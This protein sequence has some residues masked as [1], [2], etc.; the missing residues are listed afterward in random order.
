MTKKEMFANIATLLADNDEVVTFCNHEIE[1][2]EN[3][4]TSKSG[5]PTKKQEENTALKDVIRDTLAE[6]DEG[7]TATEIANA[8]NA[9][10]PKVSALLRQMTPEN[11]DGTVIR[12]T[13]GKKIFFRLADE[14]EG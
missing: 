12:Y 2:L 4:K 1:L 9:S 13:E 3:R 5:K 6:A 10:V 8:V 11:G 14:V 7:M